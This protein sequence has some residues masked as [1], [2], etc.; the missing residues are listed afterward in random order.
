MSVVGVHRDEDELTITVIAEFNAPA[1]R[2]WTLW[3][4]P[5]QLERWW[6][7]PGYPATFEPYDLVPGGKVTYS[8]RSPQGE[9][10]RAF[11]RVTLVDPPTSLEFEDVLADADGAPSADMPV[12]SV[13]VELSRRG[14]KTRMLMRSR[15]DSREA[16]EKWL[17]TGTLEG[18]Q[19]AIAQMDALIPSST[20]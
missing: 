14:G 8:M 18:L 5:R 3:S 11:W 13:K 16:L 12:S 19:Q 15:F 9:I 6:G 4:D 20:P 1:E 10:H 7:P 17:N 2:V